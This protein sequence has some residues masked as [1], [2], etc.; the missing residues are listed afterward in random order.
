MK[1]IFA[2]VA[3]LAVLSMLL[4]SAGPPV[5]E[6]P[7]TL[8]TGKETCK[9][10]SEGQVLDKDYLIQIT[11]AKTLKCEDITDDPVT[12]GT[13]NLKLVWAHQHPK[14]NGAGWAWYS[15]SLKNSYTEWTGW[16][17]GRINKDG[18]E[19][20]N[21]WGWATRGEGLW[22]TR[23]FYRFTPE[24]PTIVHGWYGNP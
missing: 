20:R 1:K 5:Q 10:I 2:A 17:L 9:V 8:F 13:V 24:D 11:M 18:V 16:R 7:L 23:L 3:I 21:G 6:K 22:G 4:V 12:S 15:F 14:Y 19:F